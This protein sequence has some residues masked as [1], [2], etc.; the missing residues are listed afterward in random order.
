MVAVTTQKRKTVKMNGMSSCT[1]LSPASRWERSRYGTRFVATAQ[2]NDDTTVSSMKDKDS[3]LGRFLVHA[4]R[5]PRASCRLWW[6][7][8]F[9]DPQ[10]EPT[11]GQRVVSSSW[12]ETSLWLGIRS[13][14]PRPLRFVVDWPFL[15]SSAGRGY[16]EVGGIRNLAVSCFVL[17]SCC[18]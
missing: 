3:S 10:Q 17:W 16:P 13:L 4:C 8:K 6:L 1:E 11:Q 12:Y 9:C 15:R 7:P 5:V 2:I 14:F 18:V